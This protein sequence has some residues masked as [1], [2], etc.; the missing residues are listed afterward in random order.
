MRYMDVNSFI[1][2]IKSVDISTYKVVKKGKK[3]KKYWSIACAYDS[4]T[5]RVNRY[6]STTYAM[7]ISIDGISVL[8]R[9]WEDLKK[10]LSAVSVHFDGAIVPIYAHDLCFDFAALSGWYEWEDVFALAPHVPLKAKIKGLGIELRD[11]GSLLGMSLEKATED[12]GIKKK[13]GALDYTKVRHYATELTDEEIDY[14]FSDVESLV[15]I[16]RERLGEYDAAHIPMTSTGYVRAHMRECMSASKYDMK[17]VQKHLT[18]CEEE[19]EWLKEA[20]GAGYSHCRGDLSD[21][22][23]TGVMSFDATSK[24]ASS[25]VRDLYPMSKGK[26]VEVKT[27]EDFWYYIKNFLCV[28]PITFSSIEIKPDSPDSPIAVRQCAELSKKHTEDDG[29]VYTAERLSLFTTSVDFEIIDDFYDYEGFDVKYMYIYQAK[30]LPTS[31]VRCVVDL[32]KRKTVLKGIPERKAAYMKAKSMLCS[33]FGMCITDPKQPVIKYVSGEWIE[34][35]VPDFIDKYN[36]NSLR[37]LYYPWGV[38]CAAYARRDLFDAISAAGSSYVYS[39]TD[40]VKAYE[41]EDFKDYIAGYNEYLREMLKKAM[42]YHGLDERDIDPT[43][44]K[45]EKKLLGEYELENTYKYFKSMGSKRY[46]TIDENGYIELT[47]AGTAKEK[48]LEYILKSVEAHYIKDAKGYKLLDEETIE[49]IFDFFTD[50]MTIPAEYSGKLAKSYSYGDS[51]FK[52]TDY[53]G[54]TVSVH[55]KGWCVLLPQSYTLNGDT[56]LINLLKGMSKVRRHIIQ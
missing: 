3:G 33:C 18:L 36:N 25:L 30:P 51:T 23:L 37:F 11:S 22:L 41:D 47:V 55:E 50:L 35:E 9:T 38:F 42:K 20:M 15:D 16:M 6:Y 52:V 4:E 27:D 34:E 49:D 14:C 24:Y 28:F 56:D 46:L 1:K 32:Y 45:G 2:A 12:R 43:N 48:S 39:D 31:F 10:A 29:K 26:K 5:S 40:C 44:L 13:V 17:Y 7:M 54:W 8:L 21:D 19:Y 53:E